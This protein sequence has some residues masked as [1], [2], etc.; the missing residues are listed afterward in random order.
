M[1]DPDHEALRDPDLSD[2]PSRSDVREPCRAPPVTLRATTVTAM[3]AEE[4]HGERVVLRPA[5]EDDVAALAAILVEPAVAA[6]WPGYDAERVRA[7]LADAQA[8]EVAGTVAGWLFTTEEA[9]PQYP[10]V[11]F[12]IALGPAYQGQGYATEPLRLAVRHWI[13]RGHHRFSIDPAAD[14]EQA[15]RAYAAVGFRPVGVMRR[16]ER[17][18]DGFR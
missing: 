12:A 11:S 17:V 6:W 2:A 16:Y 3:P 7:E 4:L 15:I 5:T 14:N 10:Q 8:I 18:G 13:A 1:L 9:D